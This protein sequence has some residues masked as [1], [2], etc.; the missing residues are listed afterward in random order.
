MNPSEEH[1]EVATLEDRSF[2][3]DA[4]RA[5]IFILGIMPR[6]GTNFLHRLLC[7]HPD[8]GAIN[9]TP[10]R[11]D[12]MTHHV[13]WLSRYVSR[14][15]WQW[16]HWGADE[17]FVAPLATHVGKGLSNFLGTLS[18]ASRIVTKTPSVTNIK[19]FFDY[20][21]HAYLIIIVRDGRSVVTSG[22]S[23]F[24]WNF[25]TASRQWGKA[26]RQILDFSKKHADLADR[27]KIVRYE[28]LNADTMDVLKEVLEFLKLDV[29]RF[30]FE[31]ALETPIFGSSFLK[32]EGD[33]VTW[34]PQ[35]KK[36]DFNTGERWSKWSSGRHNRFNW[37]A[38]KELEA[39]G[40]QAIGKSSTG[41][42]ALGHSLRDLMYHAW[43]YPGRLMRATKAGLRAF[44]KDLMGKGQANTNLKR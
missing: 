3:Q 19:S 4:A 26:A 12:Y 10:V 2:H 32:K 21:P 8:C 43:R 24:G 35:E 9:T 36:K 44:R 7:Q 17:A 31:A 15:R 40:Y 20:F 11:E 30:D 39:L 23:G 28:Q 41:F 42:S 27:F 13:N 6:S 5:P 29:D 33:Q 1:I 37:I 38:R 22:M 18:D 14:L 25:E 34:Q 16:G